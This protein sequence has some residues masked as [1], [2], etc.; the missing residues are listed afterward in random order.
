MHMGPF[1]EPLERVSGEGLAAGRA[2]VLKCCISHLNLIL[3]G[4]LLP[5]LVVNQCAGVTRT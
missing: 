4:L 2:A 5:I 3:M 1:K